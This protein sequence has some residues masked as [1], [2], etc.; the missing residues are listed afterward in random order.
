MV[1]FS[2]DLMD[3]SEQIE[4]NIADR[5]REIDRIVDFNQW[6]VID[7]FQ[8][9]QVSDYHFANSTGYGYNDRGR[10]VLDEVY[11]EVFGT[12]SALVRPHFASG[13]HTISAAL[14]GVLR[15][16]MS[17]CILP[18]DPTIRC[19]RSSDKRATAPARCGISASGMER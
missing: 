1:K 19:I 18:D 7:A 12:E 17:C 2:Q 6:K 13:T 3:L 5:V 11:A 14:F 16:G 4:W 10:E 8:K 9:Y 15:P